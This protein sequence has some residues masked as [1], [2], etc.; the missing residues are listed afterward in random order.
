MERDATKEGANKGG[1]RI[2]SRSLSRLFPQVQVFAAVNSIFVCPKSHLLGQIAD[3]RIGAA[4]TAV[5]LLV[6]DL[7]MTGRGN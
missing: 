4:Q 2:R 6:V 3:L 7:R 1:Q 5:G